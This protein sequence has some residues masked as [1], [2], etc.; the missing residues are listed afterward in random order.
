MVPVLL[1]TEARRFMHKL[2]VPIEN[3]SG[4][5]LSAT[6]FAIEFAKRNPAKLFFLIFSDFLQ[7]KEDSTVSPKK[8]DLPRKQ[9]EDLLQRARA[10]KINLE[11]FYSNEDFFEVTRQFSRDHGLTEIIIALPSE[12]DP[13]YS[14]LMDQVGLFR[15]NLESQLIL[16][17]PK[18]E[19]IMIPEGENAR[20]DQP[21]AQKSKPS[22]GKKGS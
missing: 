9:F 3:F 15:N 5:S 17:K 11:I 13:A 19:K 16:V 18:E 14:R 21:P 7:E 4:L 20:G 8:V 10:E 2:L 6:Y 12:R 1:L 22:I